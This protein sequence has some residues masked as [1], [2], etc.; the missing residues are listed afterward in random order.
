M[1]DNLDEQIK[2]FLDGGGKITVV[3][4][5]V[6]GETD[7]IKRRIVPKRKKCGKCR[8]TKNIIHFH[9]D[10]N[11]KDGHNCYCKVCGLESARKSKARKK[12]KQGY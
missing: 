11:S 9:K 1:T 4:M 12:A 3:P 5:G 7:F 2:Q 8:V 6:T 10:S